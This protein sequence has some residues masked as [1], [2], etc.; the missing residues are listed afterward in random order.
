[1]GCSQAYSD[2][3]IHVQ[4]LI[5]T[6]FPLVAAKLILLADVLLLQTFFSPLFVST[7]LLPCIAK[8]ANV[9][10]SEFSG[11]KYSFQHKPCQKLSC[12]L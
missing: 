10:I 1:M 4:P 2:L 9:F 6:I 3:L 11:A 12:H 5:V 8:E 7:T